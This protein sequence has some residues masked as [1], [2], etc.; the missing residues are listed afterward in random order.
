MLDLAVDDRERLLD[1]ERMV[2]EVALL[3]LHD[4]AQ[5]ADR[6]LQRLHHRARAAVAVGGGAQLGGVA[7]DGGVEQPHEREQ[8]RHLRHPPPHVD[9]ADEGARTDGARARPTGGEV[10]RARGRATRRGPRG[11]WP[12]PTPPS[13]PPPPPPL[14]PPPR[15]PPRRRPR[16][17]RCAAHPPRPSPATPPPATRRPPPSR[18]RPSPPPPPRAAGGGGEGR[19]CRRGRRAPAARCRAPSAGARGRGARSTR[20]G[21]RPASAASAA[22]H[23]GRVA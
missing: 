11:R 1:L 9:R 2:V 6:R 12:P 3:L 7:R 14:P 18:P 16:P 20:A 10:A 19:R 8:R 15:R 21:S 23:S 13:P 4:V 22:V 5:P 17:P